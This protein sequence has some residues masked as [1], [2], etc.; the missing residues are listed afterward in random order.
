MKVRGLCGW[1]LIDCGIWRCP[2]SIVWR[3]CGSLSFGTLAVHGR[4]GCGS[5]PMP[6]FPLKG[7]FFGS[8]HVVH[9][10]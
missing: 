6:A 7:R 1:P 4:G 2:L 8:G 3:T 10:S 9:Y 5:L